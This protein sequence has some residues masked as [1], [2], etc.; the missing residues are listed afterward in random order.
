M[1]GGSG[2]SQHMINSLRNNSIRKDRTHFDKKSIYLSSTGEKKKP[3][4]KKA[5]KE[6]L[7]K[8]KQKLQ[9]HNLVYNMKLIG[10]TATILTIMI[11]GVVIYFNHLI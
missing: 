5:T 4:F 1:M 8:I 3:Q 6:Q 7:L 10:Y 2:M 11:S 9:K